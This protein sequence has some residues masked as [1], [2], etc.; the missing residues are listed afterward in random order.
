MEYF[1]VDAFAEKVFSGNPAGVCVVEHWPAVTTM[2]CIAAENNL[3]ETAFVVKNGQNYEL[4]WFT[5]KSEIDLCGHATLATA[6]VLANYYDKTA[7]TFSF[8]TQ[9]GLL[10]VEKRDDLYEMDFPAFAVHPAAIPETATKALGGVRPMAAFLGPDLL[11]LLESEQT[12]REVKPQYDLIKTLP[13]LGLIV[14]AQC[15]SC[16]FVSR[17]FAPKLGIPEDPVTGRGHCAL[18]PFWAQKLD[19]TEMTARQL[20]ERGGA[21]YCRNLESRVKIAGKAALY[22][23]GRIGGF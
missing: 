8:E 20:S 9:S 12:V 18:I 7:N 1:V 11:L 14:T 10:T 19:K 2:Q 16:D 3:S 6:F 23:K 4:R 17:F 22:L 13:G 15:V 21:I 5:P